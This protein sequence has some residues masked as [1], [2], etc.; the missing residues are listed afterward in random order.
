M[1]FPIEIFDKIFDERAKSFTSKRD[2]H[3]FLCDMS[4]LSKKM[5]GL[6]QSHLFEKTITFHGNGS[7]DIERGRGFNN[8]CKFLTGLKENN[9]KKLPDLA[10]T[11][12]VKTIKYIL[13]RPYTAGGTDQGKAIEFAEDLQ[14]EFLGAIFTNVRKL[15]MS[16]FPT[17]TNPFGVPMFGKFL[18]DRIETLDL[19]NGFI[20][21][22][23]FV[24]FLCLFTKLQ[25]LRISDPF[26]HNSAIP[27]GLPPS[28]PD[29][30]FKGVLHLHFSGP[31]FAQEIFSIFCS[32]RFKMKYCQIVLDDRC[33]FLEERN[34]SRF[35]SKFKDTLKYL[36]FHSES[37]PS[38]RVRAHMTARRLIAI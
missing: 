22:K 17:L 18:G 28:P 5:T 1:S 6:A 2:R 25:Y 20:T 35:L 29:G 12:A 33:I 21:T 16:G 24:D 7:L 15:E 32:I 14:D 11:C 9:N 38:Y 3:K 31:Y 37:T 34:L 23:D 10:L 4:L 27:Q 26:V 8:W 36:R 13:I 30:T 19:T